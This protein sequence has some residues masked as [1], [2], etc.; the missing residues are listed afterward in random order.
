MKR[1]LILTCLTILACGMFPLPA[2]AAQ[3]QGLLIS[4]PRTYS[5]VDAGHE[6]INTITIANTTASPMHV[7]LSVQQFSVN[8]YVYTQIFSAVKQDWLHL[9]ANSVQLAAN[10]STTVRYA[11]T[12]PAN[13]TPGGYYF[14]IFA[15]TQIR[16]DGGTDTMQAANL[17]YVTVNGTLTKTSQLKTSHMPHF[18]FGNTIPYQF[19]VT[20]TGNVHFFIYTQS[21]LN[22]LFTKQSSISQTHIL[23][24]ATT[25]AIASSMQS[26]LLPGL[27]H[28]MYGYKT[29]NDITVTRTQWILYIPFWFIAAIGVIVLTLER[30]HL[31]RRSKQ[32]S[33]KTNN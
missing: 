32:N 9:M 27:Y 21:T 30:L 33:K 20:D 15:S 28:A 14:S 1:L 3:T 11:L 2:H 18:V 26:P 22:G 24:P 7:T 6:K 16:K 4:P 12:P 8:D 25:R 5:S 19:S 10:Q 23:L 31:K 17:L 29:D 13:V